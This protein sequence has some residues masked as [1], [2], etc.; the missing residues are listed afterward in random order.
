MNISTPLV[1]FVNNTVYCVPSFEEKVWKPEIHDRHDYY[2]KVAFTPDNFHFYV[3][4]PS[5]SESTCTTVRLIRYQH[6]E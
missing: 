4:D 3:N 1:S 2:T 6:F 5:K